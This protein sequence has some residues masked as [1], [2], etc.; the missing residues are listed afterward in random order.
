MVFDLIRM[1]LPR[2]LDA[3]CCE[4]KSETPCATWSPTRR[5]SARALHVRSGFPR[6]FVHGTGCATL[7]VAVTAPA[8]EYAWEISGNR[9]QANLSGSSD[10]TTTAVAA[11][12]YFTP[13]D[14]TLGP[15]RYG[16]FLSRSS[17]I[18]GAVRHDTREYLGFGISPTPLPAV[19]MNLTDRTDAYTVSGRY[20]WRE[21][22]WYA[23]GTAQR[24]S[25][26]VGQPL[27]TGA[28]LDGYSAFGGKYL[29]RA[30]T[31]DLTLESM[32]GR[33]DVEPIVCVNFPCVVPTSTKTS[34]KNVGLAVQRLGKLAAMHYV[35]AGRVTSTRTEV[36]YDVAAT[37]PFPP[38]PSLSNGSVWSERRRSYAASGELLP[39]TRVGVRLDYT[40]FGNDLARGDAYGVSTTWFFK[41]HVAVQFSWLHTNPGGSAPS[42]R[43]WGVASLGRF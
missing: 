17:E 20:V 2:A 38:P 35:V 30:M 16:A 22:G 41:R 18:T 31:L 27:V 36:R 13:V 3:R 1:L 32:K 19:A 43:G 25:T 34:T 37:L 40:S 21:S 9:S 12:H 33:T 8:D 5:T 10:A 15:Y 4:P 14:D 6:W 7:L 39:T 11:T 26:D 29:G 24:A 42:Y 23:G 28:T